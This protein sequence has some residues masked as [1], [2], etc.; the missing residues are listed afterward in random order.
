[1]MVWRK[2][3]RMDESVEMTVLP[4]VE[5]TVWW[6]VEV[7]VWPKA[8]RMDESVELTVLQKVE[9]TVWRK[10]QRRDESV[11]MTVLPKVDLTELT[12]LVIRKVQ[13]MD[14]PQSQSPPS[15]KCCTFYLECVLP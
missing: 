2:A 10:V 15:H 3:E 7:M 8:E 12:I 5:L 9:Q 4:K 14:T 11:E 1:M 13:R 6:K